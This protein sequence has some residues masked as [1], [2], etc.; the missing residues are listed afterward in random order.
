[1]E[2]FLSSTA[3]PSAIQ[4]TTAANLPASEVVST[5]LDCRRCGYNLRSISWQSVC[6]GCGLNL[7][8]SRLPRFVAINSWR[9]MRQIRRGTQLLLFSVVLE[10]ITRIP[11]SIACL[12]W[13]QLLAA[14]Y[15]W[16]LRGIV[17]V[18]E[19]GDLAGEAI[20]LVAVLLL[21][22][23]NRSSD[24]TTRFTNRFVMAL[25]GLEF[26]AVIA[27]SEYPSALV[28]A[29]T[30]PRAAQIISDGV[31][32]ALL[33]SKPF[34]VWMVLRC[35]EHRTGFRKGAWGRWALA[36]AAVA[37]SCIAA[38]YLL[39]AGASTAMYVLA[40]FFPSCGTS[41]SWRIDESHSGTSKLYQRAD[42]WMQNVGGA[43]WMVLLLAFYR[44]VRGVD[45][46]LAAPHNSG[47]KGA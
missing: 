26:L 40:D 28:V 41:I 39:K 3:E 44:L 21:L 38:A 23:T 18:W 32:V 6:P 1:M 19:Y 4:R 15:R 34:V 8:E 14:G 11:M 25:A 36:I 31:L 47:I 10:W 13:L 42:W 20:W 37:A 2:Q 30:T 45:R 46:S 12:Y 9:E 29:W 24:Q 5:D 16:L 43:C 33:A 27:I 35:L 7:A 22:S 17:R